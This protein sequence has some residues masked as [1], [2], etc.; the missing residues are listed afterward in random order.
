MCMKVYNKVVVFA[1]VFTYKDNFKVEKTHTRL[2]SFTE[3]ESKRYYSREGFV[4][5]SM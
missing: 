1:T 3:D 4:S 2:K 5:L